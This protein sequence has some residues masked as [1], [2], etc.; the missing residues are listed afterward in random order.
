[1]D[2]LLNLLTCPNNMHSSHSCVFSK[3]IWWAVLSRLHQIMQS[4]DEITR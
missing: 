3:T 4:L 1:M 2:F